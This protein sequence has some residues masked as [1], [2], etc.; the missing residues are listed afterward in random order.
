MAFKELMKKRSLLQSM[1]VVGLG[2]AVIGFAAIS[3]QATG[4][5]LETSWD[6]GFYAI[7]GWGDGWIDPVTGL[8]IDADNPL[9]ASAAYTLTP[10]A[11]T[12]Y[13]YSLQINQSGYAQSLQL[14]LNSPADGLGSEVA[15][16]LNNTVLSFQFAVPASTATSGW[17]QIYQ[18]FLNAPGLGYQN[19]WGGGTGWSV[20]FTDV[21]GTNNNGTDPNYYYGPYSSVRSETVSIN[22]TG[23]VPILEADGVSPTSG[24]LQL[25]FALN[26]GGGAPS[27]LYLNNVALTPEPTTGAM[28]LAGGALAL[29]WVRRRAQ[30]T[31]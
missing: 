13:A 14:N 23:L 7:G 10:N 25:I 5:M 11:V 30:K 28:L 8:P 27:Y 16:F 2:A 20:N 21:Y 18:L 22:Y 15:P 24:Y 17:S 19:L 31:A 9:N 3:A 4:Y 1:K 29:F 26:T 12:G 6:S